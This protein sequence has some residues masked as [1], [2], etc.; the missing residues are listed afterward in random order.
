MNRMPV[1]RII[2]RRQ[3]KIT[4]IY[5]IRRSIINSRVICRP[6]IIFKGKVDSWLKIPFIIRIK[7]KMT[8]V[9]IP[10]DINMVICEHVIIIK[11]LMRWFTLI[12]IIFLNRFNPR[13]P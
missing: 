4:R 6:I 13:Y 11:L 5:V 1:R 9:I 3:A 8:R 2:Y 12:T 10:A 7:I